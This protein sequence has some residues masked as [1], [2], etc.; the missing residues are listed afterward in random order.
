LPGGLTGAPLPPAL[1]CAVANAVAAE[2]SIERWFNGQKPPSLPA[3][4]ACHFEDIRFERQVLAQRPAGAGPFPSASL[5]TLG[6][7]FPSRVELGATLARVFLP[8]VFIRNRHGPV[9]HPSA[10]HALE[11]TPSP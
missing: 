7:S 11:R 3:N 5:A 4:P 10:R 8:S 9:A 1:E 6:F 2:L